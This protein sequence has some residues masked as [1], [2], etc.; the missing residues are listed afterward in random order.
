MFDL[1]RI[2]ECWCLATGKDPE[3]FNRIRLGVE[4]D[5][6]CSKA[7]QLMDRDPSGLLSGI[8]MR[9]AYRKFIK[10]NTCTVEDLINGEWD[11]LKPKFEALRAELYDKNVGPIVDQTIEG[12]LNT[13]R[14]FGR[15]ITLQELMEQDIESFLVDSFDKYPHYI[16]DVF[17]KPNKDDFRGNPRI[18]NKLFRFEHYKQFVTSLKQAPEDNCIVVAIIDRTSETDETD[19]DKRYDKFFAFGIKRDGGVA[20]VSDRTYYESLEHSYKTRNPA[21][22][23]D[24]KISYSHFPYHKLDEIYGLTEQ[25]SQLLLP[26]PSSTSLEN[27]FCSAFDL[28]GYIYIA[29]VLSL[30][31]RE[32][33]NYDNNDRWDETLKW[34]GSDIKYLTSAQVQALVVRDKNILELPSVSTKAKDYCYSTQAFNNGV[35]DMYVDKYPIPELPVL[36]ANFIDTLENAQRNAWWLVRKKQKEH[37]QQ[38]L[39]GSDYYRKLRETIEGLKPY[40]VRAVPDLLSYAFT[41]GDVTLYD[42]Y[43]MSAEGSKKDPNKKIFWKE[44]RDHKELDTVTVKTNFYKKSSNFFTPTRYR[45]D[46]IT[47]IGNMKV[48]IY[49]NH[50]HVWW[51][52]DNDR[53]SV[54]ITVMLRSYSDLKKWLKL[55][56]VPSEFEFYFYDRYDHW[57]LYGWKPYDGNSILHFT[58]P[59]DYISDPCCKEELSVVF[60]M[61]KS[62]YKE[63]IKQ[64]GG[65]RTSNIEKYYDVEDDD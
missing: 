50:L 29:C 49:H 6:L 41:Q 56:K 23:M 57:S 4:S 61:S 19:Y 45:S 31:V 44:F 37:I 54:E 12:I 2:L 5:W 58:D 20:V 42:K 43:N 17:V 1:N 32:Y 21:R 38:C 39:S 36:S 10:E 28:E 13:I 51:I 7:K 34:F 8:T 30:I 55:E 35:Y 48:D 52:K 53:R 62:Q 26:P 15:D 60:H 9:A 59:M 11:E 33:F 16:K 46:Y 63:L 3:T 24:N 40:M 27:E 14:S 47:T 64:Y 22:D 18:V 25:S 65:P